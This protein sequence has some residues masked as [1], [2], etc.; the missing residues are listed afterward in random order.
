MTGARE[1]E[2][3]VK[4]LEARVESDDVTVKA[5]DELGDRLTAVIDEAV[6]DLTIELDDL[7]RRFDALARAIAK[8]AGAD[9]VVHS[10]SAGPG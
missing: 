2:R 10:D 1:L 5:I 7:K 6:N 3:H 9:L 4:L 8:L